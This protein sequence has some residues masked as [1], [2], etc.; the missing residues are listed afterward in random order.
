MIEVGQRVAISETALNSFHPKYNLLQNLVRSKAV[1]T[2]TNTMIYDALGIIR[3]GT[4]LTE[5]EFPDNEVRIILSPD[6]LR[7]AKNS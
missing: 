4:W 1:G 2:V 6:D 3:W 5:V 7:Q